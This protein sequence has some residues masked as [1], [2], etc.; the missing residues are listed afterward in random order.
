MDE[1]AIEV[2]A[3]GLELNH[4]AQLAVD[5]TVRSAV[6]ACGRARPNASTVDGAVLTEARHD[7]EAKCAELCEG[8]RCQLVV[9]GIET[10]GRWS[11]EAL[12][13]V[14]QLAAS[15]AREAPSALRFSTFLAWRR[16]W[17]RMLSISC[18]RAFA[19]SLVSSADDQL[20][21]TDGCV[22][23]LADLFSA[24]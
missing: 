4:G 23:E 17:C 3:S 6:T 21:G 16:R 15:R 10:G 12:S 19:G 9:V 18:S 1:R 20:E 8:G 2:L 13:F 24:E 5:I 7:K 14:E 11:P 22:P